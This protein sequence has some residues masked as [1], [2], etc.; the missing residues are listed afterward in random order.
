MRQK[1]IT[2][3]D[4]LETCLGK[5]DD[6]TYQA[7]GEEKNRFLFVFVMFAYYCIITVVLML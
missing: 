2:L 7:P 1:S 4:L 6:G 5:L 3:K